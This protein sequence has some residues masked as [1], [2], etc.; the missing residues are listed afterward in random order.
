[1]TE[2]L[3]FGLVG[4]LNAAVAISTIAGV[5]FNLQPSSRLVFHRRD[6]LL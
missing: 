5:L 3:R 4:L 1:M 2:I 6:H